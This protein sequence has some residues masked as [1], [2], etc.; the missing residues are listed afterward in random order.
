MA[1]YYQ[2]FNWCGSGNRLC[3][4]FVT[5]VNNI[6]PR[7]RG[8]LWRFYRAS[9]CTTACGYWYAYR[10]NCL[11]VLSVHPSN[12]SIVWKRLYVVKRPP[13]NMPLLKWVTCQF[14]HSES[15]ARNKHTW[16]A[17]PKNLDPLDPAFQG[18]SN[19]TERTHF[20][21]YVE[22]ILII[23]SNSGKNGPIS[24]IPFQR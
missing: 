5:L 10:I 11:S 24:V 7:I 14:G 23:Y 21:R 17:L 18:H 6:G 12:A 20:D 8:A 19:S 4:Q 1:V 15:I 2:K 16:T 3:G 13:R 9:A 22:I